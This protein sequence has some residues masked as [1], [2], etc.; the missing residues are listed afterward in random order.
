MTRVGPIMKV[1]QDAAVVDP[2]MAEQWA[3]N[4]TQTA[5]A[6]RVLAEQLEAMGALRPPVEEPPTSSAPSPASACTSSWPDEDGTPSSGNAS[7]STP[8][9]TP[10][11]ADRPDTTFRRDLLQPTAG[12]HRDL[13]RR[14]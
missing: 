5:A 7:S 3:T 4:E 2:E 13:R 10:C 9:P 8:S 11:C 14:R 6:F 12:G 1:V